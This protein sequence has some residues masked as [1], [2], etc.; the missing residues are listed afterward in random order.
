MHEDNDNLIGY[1]ISFSHELCV[2]LANTHL[3]QNAERANGNAHPGVH[4]LVLEQARPETG[5]QSTRAAIP[6]VLHGTT[7]MVLG[8]SSI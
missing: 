7:R 1:K 4:V 2:H 8:F 5:P 3:P 6:S